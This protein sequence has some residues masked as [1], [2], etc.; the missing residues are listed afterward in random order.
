MSEQRHKKVLKS[1]GWTDILKKHLTNYV[2][3]FPHTSYGIRKGETRVVEW[4]RRGRAMPK[5]G[6]SPVIRGRVS[7]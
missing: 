3:E 4:V 2:S 6:K 1:L 5:Y 7:L